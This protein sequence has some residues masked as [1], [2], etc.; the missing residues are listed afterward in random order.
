MQP[1][2]V[3]VVLVFLVQMTII[4]CQT[5][6]GDID[7]SAE[8]QPLTAAEQYIDFI[9]SGGKEEEVIDDEN[10]VGGPPVP[11]G[12]EE[13]NSY[14]SEEDY[15][16]ESLDLLLSMY[17]HASKGVSGCGKSNCQGEEQLSR[18]R[19]IRFKI[20]NRKTREF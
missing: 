5:E 11:E 1:T 16:L 14:D 17:D 8:E 20:Y 4:Y 10:D 18:G 9:T 3:L 6:E 2:K 7:E 15:S 12:Y 13:V 19:A